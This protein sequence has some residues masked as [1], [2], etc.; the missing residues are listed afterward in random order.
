LLFS[1]L[2]ELFSA[3]VGVETDTE[4]TSNPA[5]EVDDNRANGG[6]GVGAW[7]L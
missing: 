6:V 1:C 5:M 3:A 2:K 4:A 7:M